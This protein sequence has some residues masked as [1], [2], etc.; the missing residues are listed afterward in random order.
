MSQSSED[1][2]NPATNRKKCTF[3]SS[4]TRG[5]TVL[6][7]TYAY[8]KVMV[9]SAGL[10]SPG[11]QFFASPRELDLRDG[12]GGGRLAHVAISGQSAW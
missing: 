4:V 3:V 2:L 1:R 6:S 8:V 5:Y 11:P 12:S 7:L 10:S 9:A